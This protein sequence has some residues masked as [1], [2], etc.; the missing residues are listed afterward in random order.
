MSIFRLHQSVIDDYTQY[1]KSFF[2]VLDDRIREYVEGALVDEHKLWPDALI[3]L[4]PCYEEAGSISDLT[5]EGELHHLCAEVFRAGNGMPFRL[6][7]HQQEAIEK[8]LAH[9]HYIVTSGTGSG[10]TLTFLIPIFDRIP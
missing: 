3:Q 4:N 6:F 10:K 8:A 5:G 7:R 1:V 2:S 9:N